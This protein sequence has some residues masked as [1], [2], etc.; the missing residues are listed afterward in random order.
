MENSTIL[1]YTSARKPQHKRDLLN[2]ICY[3]EGAKIQFAYSKKWI[4]KHLLNVEVFNGKEA[5]IVFCEAPGGDPSN[6]RFHPVRWVKIQNCIEDDEGYCFKLELGQLQYY[7]LNKDEVLTMLESFNKV[8]NA[9]DNPIKAKGGVFVAKLS[10]GSNFIKSKNWN[11]LVQHFKKLYAIDDCCFFRLNYDDIK[12]I[13]L[14]EMVQS[15]EDFW[16]VKVKSG[17]VKTIEFKSIAGENYK[18]GLPVPKI[19]ILS[20]SAEV[21]GPIVSQYSE[22]IKCKY[23]IHFYSQIQQQHT[24]LRMYIPKDKDTNFN[25]PSFD[26]YL[27]ISPN[28]CLLIFIILCICSVPFL[29]SISISVGMVELPA[30]G[31]AFVLSFVGYLLLFRKFKVI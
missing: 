27:E 6:T 30:K 17:D 31:M 14:K 28:W 3:P 24:M 29:A 11:S 20:S 2:I 1:L 7:S 5:L 26:G 8:A 15:A 12:K 9:Q 16:N 13:F 22:G 10:Q 19:D 23:R 4:P 21:Q 25:A 18:E